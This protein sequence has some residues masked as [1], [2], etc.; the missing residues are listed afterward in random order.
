[1]TGPMVNEAGKPVYGADAL[2]V[3]VEHMRSLNRMVW[4]MRELLTTMG[5]PDDQAKS[6]LD[7][8]S[9]KGQQ[10]TDL[11]SYAIRTFNDDEQLVRFIRGEARTYKGGL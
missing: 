6:L 1:M 8:W 4:L 2:E 11:L 3:A 7:D 5:V 9:T 10:V